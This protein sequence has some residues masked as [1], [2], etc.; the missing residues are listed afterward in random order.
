V[1]PEL[2]DAYRTAGHNLHAAADWY[3]LQIDEWGW[4]IVLVWQAGGLIAVWCGIGAA[5]H[6][7]GWLRDRRDERRD[8]AAAWRMQCTAPHA[9]QR[10]PGTDVGLYLDCVAIYSDCDELDRLRDAIDQHRTGEK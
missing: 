8:R 10:Q 7:S 2:Y 6:L 4:P 5:L 3:L 9:E 1:S